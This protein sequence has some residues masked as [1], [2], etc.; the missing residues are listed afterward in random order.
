[1]SKTKEKDIPTPCCNTTWTRVSRAVF[2]CDKCKEDV[3]VHIM[4]MY[5]AV[6]DD[7]ATTSK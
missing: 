4:L 5:Q 2:L 7:A 3:T 6:N 1:M